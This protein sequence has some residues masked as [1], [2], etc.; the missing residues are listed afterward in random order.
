MDFAFITMG[1]CTMWQ[2]F[3]AKTG[4]YHDLFYFYLLSNFTKNT[5]RLEAKNKSPRN[6][7]FQLQFLVTSGCLA[8]L[9]I[10]ISVISTPH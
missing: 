4:S 7:Q 10:K 9:A 8:L 1:M 5:V 6:L 3:Q 2:L